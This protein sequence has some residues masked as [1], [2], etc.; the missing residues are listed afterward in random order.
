MTTLVEAKKSKIEGT[1]LFA[2]VDITKGT[3]VTEYVG[4]KVTKKEGSKR[5]DEQERL[6]K[7]MCV[8]SLNNRYDIDGS[9]NGNGAEYGNHSCDPNCEV[10][11]ID[12]HIWII[13]IQDIKKDE[14]ITYDYCFESNAD[15]TTC[16]CGKTACRG[17]I[18]LDSK[19]KKRGKKR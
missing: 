18:N 8:F 19:K 3:R 7:P 12:G 4:E 11:N 14:E 17:T 6:G 2:K 10:D 1:G 13:A 9:V 15:I 5:S 16:K